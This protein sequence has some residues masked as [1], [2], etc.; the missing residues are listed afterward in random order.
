MTDVVALLGRSDASLEGV[1]EGPWEVIDPPWGDGTWVGTERD[2]HQGIYIAQTVE[3]FEEDDNGRNVVADA[4][5]IAES[6]SL[7]PELRDAL[8]ERTNHVHD[9]TVEDGWGVCACGYRTKNNL[10]E[11]LEA[12]KTWLHETAA[13]FHHRYPAETCPTCACIDELERLL[14]IERPPRAALAPEEKA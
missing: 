7:V 8:R 4:R 12:I 2:P 10:T 1:T 14:G 9:L 6:R 11:C 13:A 3:P 5:F